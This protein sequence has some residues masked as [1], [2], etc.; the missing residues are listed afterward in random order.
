[1]PGALTAPSALQPPRTLRSPR[2]PGGLAHFFNSSI[3]ESKPISNKQQIISYASC[4][5]C[6]GRRLA[7]PRAICSA[8]MP[9]NAFK[10]RS[11]SGCPF[12]VKKKRKCYAQVQICRNNS[13][14]QYRIPTF[15]GM[16]RT[17]GSAPCLNS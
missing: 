5:T 1:M 17:P 16:R 12:L 6:T 2:L 11:L 4:R 9:N 8:K 15:R 13:S 10:G 3:H 7:E 14:T